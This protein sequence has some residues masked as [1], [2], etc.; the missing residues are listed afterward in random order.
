MHLGE[1]L[2]VPGVTEECI[3][4]PDSK[5]GIMAL[6]GGSQDRGTHHIARLTAEQSGSSIYAIIQP[7]DIR[8]HLTSRLHEPV[9][10]PALQGFLDHVEIAVSVHGFG[11]DGFAFWLDPALGPARV[12]QP[13][14]PPVRGTQTGPLTGIIVGGGN[15]ELTARA[16]AIFHDRIDGYHVADERLRLGFHPQNPVNLPRQHGVQVELPPGL[17]GIGPYGDRLVPDHDDIPD[18]LIDALVE[19]AHDAARIAASDHPADTNSYH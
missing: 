5:V 4:R 8:I 19:L 6:H 3:L 14:G 2:A 13:Y 15:A 1:L 18:E 9:H 11:R 16:R 17:R 7:A 10:S 12:I